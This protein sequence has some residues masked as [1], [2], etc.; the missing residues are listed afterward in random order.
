MLNEK[1]QIYT[2]FKVSALTRSR[3]N[4]WYYSSCWAC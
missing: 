2:N 1:Q 4:P 3:Q